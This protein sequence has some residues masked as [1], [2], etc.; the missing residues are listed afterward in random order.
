[1]DL[2]KSRSEIKRLIKSDGIKI[3]NQVYNNNDYN[4]TEF[5]SLN[6]VKIS[7]GKKRIGILKILV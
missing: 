1:M 2:V 3:N 6:E 5:L 4:L 7:V